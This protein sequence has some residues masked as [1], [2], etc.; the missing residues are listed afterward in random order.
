M[1]K[2][3]VVQIS[4]SVSIASVTIACVSHVECTGL[5]FFR[6]FVH[7]LF[8]LCAVSCLFVKQAHMASFSS[9]FW[10]VT[11]IQSVNTRSS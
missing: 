8:L 4:Q 6:L 2:S 10:V 7:S 3:C 1:Y 9:E 11:K 5:H